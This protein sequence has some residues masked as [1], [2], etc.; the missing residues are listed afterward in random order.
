MKINEENFILLMKEGREESLSY[1]IKNYGGLI[2]KVVS[3]HLNNFEIFHGEC[4]NDVY[5]A[6][7]DNVN[8][9][10]NSRSSFKNWVV[11]IARY[12]AID[13]GRQVKASSKHLLN[14]RFRNW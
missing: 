5:L 2:N 9:F 3:T 6:I 10:D 11:G 8:S 1:V 12:K 4:V 7:W 14:K 13:I